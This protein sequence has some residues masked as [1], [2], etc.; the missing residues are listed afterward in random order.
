MQ[1]PVE[2]RRGGRIPK[3]LD[4]HGCEF[5]DVGAGNQLSSSR[6]TCALVFGLFVCLFCCFEGGVLFSFL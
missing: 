4:C 1:V 2:A 3:G 6:R 5:P